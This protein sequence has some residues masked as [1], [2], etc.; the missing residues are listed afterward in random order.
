MVVHTCKSAWSLR[1]KLKVQ[2]QF[3]LN[4]KT[5]FQNTTNTHTQNSYLP[6][7]ELAM[8]GSDGIHL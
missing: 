8:W 7:K 2:D 1:E 3:K 6:L 4:T 5:L